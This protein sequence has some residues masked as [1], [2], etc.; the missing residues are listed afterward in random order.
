M[1]LTLFSPANGSLS[2]P[3]SSFLSPSPVFSL[4]RASQ[5]AC[6]RLPLPALPLPGPYLPL[7]A[8]PLPVSLS[9]SASLPRI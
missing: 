5:A 3:V 6:P 2:L 7:P 4:P 1:P 9:L 8:L